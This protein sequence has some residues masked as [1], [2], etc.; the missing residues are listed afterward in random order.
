MLW[1]VRTFGTRQ[2]C[3]IL[4]KVLSVK[5]TQNPKTVETK[6][7]VKIAPRKI[8][9]EL[10]ILELTVQDVKLKVDAVRTRQAPELILS[11]I[12]IQP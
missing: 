1:E 5:G 6:E 2:W 9:Q 7:L 8:V 11:Y 3:E 10:N 4:W 12:S